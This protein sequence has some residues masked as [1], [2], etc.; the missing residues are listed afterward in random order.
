MAREIL[1]I[2][3]CLASFNSWCYCSVAVGQAAGEG[4]RQG[5]WKAWWEGGVRG[6]AAEGRWAARGPS[7]QLPQNLVKEMSCNREEDASE[8][9]QPPEG[10]AEKPV[11]TARS[12]GRPAGLECRAEPDWGSLRW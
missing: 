4:Q 3:C 5:S 6:E 9:G 10:Q 12:Q 1:P 2:F 11:E 8:K 7:N